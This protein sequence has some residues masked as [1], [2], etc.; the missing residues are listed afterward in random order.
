MNALTPAICAAAI[1]AMVGSGFGVC[2]ARAVWADDLRQAQQLRTIWDKSEKA[3]RNTI[4]SLEQTIK[5][6]DETIS[7]LSSKRS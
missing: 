6:K 3:M 5:L 4:S 7:R 2:I 1:L